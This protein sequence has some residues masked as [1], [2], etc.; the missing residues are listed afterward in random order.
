MRHTTADTYPNT[1]P[2]K[3]LYQVAFG[4]HQVAPVTVEVA[5]RSN[6]AYIHTPVA[7]SL[8]RWCPR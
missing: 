2:K 1:P 7:R 4:D 6:G 5:A 3:I 8:A